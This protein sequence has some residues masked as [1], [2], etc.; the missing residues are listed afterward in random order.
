MLGVA[1]WALVTVHMLLWM[2]KWLK[3]GTLI[4]NIVTLDY[5]QIT[6]TNVSRIAVRT[7]PFC[8]PTRACVL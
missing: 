7:F 2:I 8:C 4:N 5:L 6:P 3:E 1:V